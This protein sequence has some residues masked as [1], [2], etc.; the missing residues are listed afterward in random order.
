MKRVYISG[1]ITGL[2][3]RVAR[4]LFDLGSSIVKEM[5]HL[6]INPME[7]VSENP[8]MSWEEY[9]KNDIKILMDCHAIYMLP[10]WTDSRG[11]KMEHMIAKDLNMEV[12]YHNKTGGQPMD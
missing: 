10:N 5:G 4:E 2:D 8:D 11:A 7:L 3:I 9:M 12:L 1:K 6:P